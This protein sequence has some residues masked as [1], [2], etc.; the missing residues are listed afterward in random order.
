ME[1]KLKVG[2]IRYFSYELL[3]DKFVPGVVI[4]YKN[5]ALNNKV[6]VECYLVILYNGHVTTFPIETTEIKTSRGL[7]PVIRESLT[8]LCRLYTEMEKAERARAKQQREAIKTQPK[9]KSL[10][11]IDDEDYDELPEIEGATPT[12]D[13]KKKHTEGIEGA[14]Q[15]K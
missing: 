14:R 2:D 10:H 12:T 11:Y 7:K 9:V 3:K 6:K 1:K 15:T 4:G 8:E 5:R 13:D